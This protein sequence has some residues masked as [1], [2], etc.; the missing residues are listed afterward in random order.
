MKQGL[1]DARAQPVTHQAKSWVMSSEKK[2]KNMAVISKLITQYSKQWIQVG[3]FA[4]TPKGRLELS[5]VND[6]TIV[7]S[8]N[9]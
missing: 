3:G 5:K 8:N 1:A 7:Y 6:Q 2:Y 9:V 4:V